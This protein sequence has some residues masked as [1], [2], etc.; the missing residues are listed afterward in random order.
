NNTG[1]GIGFLVQ[2][3]GQMSANVYNNLISQNGNNG[4]QVTES[5]S[6]PLDLRFVTGAW[7]HNTITQNTGDGIAIDGRIFNVQIGSDAVPSDGNMIARNTLWGINLTGSGSMTVS[8]NDITR[9]GAGGTGGGVGIHP[10]ETNY[11]NADNTTV[12]LNRNYIHLNT[13]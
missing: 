4:I 3:D 5:A 8:N 6:S 10:G 9:N 2:A 13:G 1:R 7:Q 11:D 12:T